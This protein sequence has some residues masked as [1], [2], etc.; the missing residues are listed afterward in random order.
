MVGYSMGRRRC[1]EL[2]VMAIL[3]VAMGCNDVPQAPNPHVKAPRLVALGYDN[4]RVGLVHPIL[5]DFGF[6]QSL[7]EEAERL[8]C[9]PFAQPTGLPACNWTRLQ[10]F[11]D[12]Q[13]RPTWIRGDTV[14]ALANSPP[15][16]GSV[17]IMVRVDGVSTELGS[18]WLPGLSTKCYPIMNNLPTLVGPGRIA[19]R[20]GAGVAQ[21]IEL[22]SCE[23]T[24]LRDGRQPGW[25]F[26]L[27]YRDPHY[28]VLETRPSS[29]VWDTRTGELVD[30]IPCS[31]Y[32]MNVE[33]AP[34]TCFSTENGQTYFSSNG[35][36]DRIQTGGEGHG[37]PVVSAAGYAIMINEVSNYVLSEG[38]PVFGPDSI[39]YLVDADKVLAASFSDGRLDL[40][41]GI[42]VPRG[43]QIHESSGDYFLASYTASGEL[44]DNVP[45]DTDM[46]VRGA[47]KM[48]EGWLAWGLAN[49]RLVQ[50]D[51]LFVFRNTIA[52]EMKA[53]TIDSGT[54]EV[55][56][57]ITLDS[58]QGFQLSGWTESVRMFPSRD[59]SVFYLHAFAEG[60]YG[61]V[62]Q[63][64][65]YAPQRLGH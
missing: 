46:I 33:V 24:T 47:I 1:V 63:K 57:M 38:I 19:A 62:V 28:V 5:A 14:F 20:R 35:V 15:N 22:E 44:M 29:E 65:E 30:S 53:F 41:G 48:E 12:G 6:V 3:A 7:S 45:I 64:V 37:D 43:N 39:A 32:E 55:S 13:V 42:N 50:Q 18:V 51:D 23:A 25:H 56:N 36:V 8:E 61:S 40:I 59:P 2:A 21:T 16:S 34:E 17:S 27:S 31:A 54:G 49:V 10:I 9:E 58:R 11:L 52:F 4:S 26:G 60:T